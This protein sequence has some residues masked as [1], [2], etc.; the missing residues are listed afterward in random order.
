MLHF[1]LLRGNLYSLFRRNYSKEIQ[2]QKNL[3][4][5]AISQKYVNQDTSNFYSL[6]YIK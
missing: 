6:I 4:I 1:F 2:K 5:E 3:R